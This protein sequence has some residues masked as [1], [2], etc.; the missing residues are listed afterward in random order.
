MRFGRRRSDRERVRVI[1]R[2][3]PTISGA[4][5]EEIMRLRRAMNAAVTDLYADRPDAARRR[6]SAALAERWWR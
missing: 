3:L 5:A 1:Q 6:L 2:N 4:W